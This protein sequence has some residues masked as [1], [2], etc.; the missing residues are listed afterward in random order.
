[1]SCIFCRYGSEAEHVDTFFENEHAIVIKTLGPLAPHHVLI[2][3][4]KHFASL[5][6]LTPED[7][8]AVLPA[9]FVLV[10]DYVKF[11]KLHEGGYRTVIN[12]GRD[13]WQTMFHLHMHIIGGA[14]LKQDIA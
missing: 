7:Q 11:A 2:V 10:S 6:D 5:S 8:K 3:P 1:M 12:T 13:A 14:L 9:M 4:R